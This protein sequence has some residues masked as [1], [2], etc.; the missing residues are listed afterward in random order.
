MVQQM[1]VEKVRPGQFNEPHARFEM[2]RAQRVESELKEWDAFGQMQVGLQGEL[3]DNP[4]V[5]LSSH[6]LKLR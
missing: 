3:T 1:E 4:E 2:E 5:C 6:L